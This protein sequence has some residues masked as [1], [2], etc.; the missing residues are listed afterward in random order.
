VDAA[1]ASAC[2]ADAVHE[3]LADHYLAAVPLPTCGAPLCVVDLDGVLE[4][5]R[6]G[7]PATGPA[8]VLA[9]AALR[10]HGYSPVLATGRS[11]ADVRDRCTVFGLAGGVG[12]YGAAVYD[13]GD[14]TVED[15]RSGEERLLLERVRTGLGRAGYD[16]DPRYRYCVRVRLDG[17]RLPEDALRAVP[18]L[19]DPRLHVVHG[20][21][22]TDVTVRRLDKGHG[23]RVL[24]RHLGAVD[25]ALAVGDS[26]SDLPMLAQARIARAPRNADAAVR[27]AGVRLTRRAYRLGLVDACVELL[28]HLPG[29]CPVCRPPRPA[30]RARALLTLLAL[31]DGGVRTVASQTLRVAVLR[32]RDLAHSLQRRQRPAYRGRR[33]DHRRLRG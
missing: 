6:L 13:A 29:R 17:R 30:R 21:G 3:Y 33:V 9:L 16:V 10:A 4:T 28:G 15:L 5:D 27:A 8:G 1:T 25:V 19:A 31:H 12:E 20:Q 32:A 23:L 26:A 7:Y 22:Q 24:A 14:E 2:R 18:L 11:V